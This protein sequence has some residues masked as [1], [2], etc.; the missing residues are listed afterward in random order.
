LIHRCIQWAKKAVCPVF[1]RRAILAAGI[2]VVILAS[3]AAAPRTSARL[4]QVRATDAPRNQGI[5]FVGSSIFQFWRHLEEQMAPLPVL[6]RAVAGTVTQDQLDRV[7]Q[8][9]FPYKP[10][11]VVYYCG[12]ND[13]SAG[14]S[15]EPIIARTKRFIEVVHEKLP[16]TFI[17]YTA[18]QKAPE[19]RDRWNIVEAVNREME[20]YS[21]ET[22]NL[23]FI[24]LNP[25]LFDRQGKLREN[26]FLPDELHF[27]PDSTAYQ[28]FADVVKPVL[29]KA[30][31]S[32]VGLSKG[33]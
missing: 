15:A 16:D 12:S 23:G 26:L 10:R 17:Y 8:F 11:I 13:I 7:G 22:R 5:L 33:N 25:V 1:P 21:R 30:W 2:S 29:T 18:I 14:E 6:N 3:M 32:G 9:V 27:R 24:D 28:E 19:K 31:Q 20:R 4:Y